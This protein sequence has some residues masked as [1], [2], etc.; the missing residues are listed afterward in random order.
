MARVDE[1]EMDL[2][3][4]AIKEAIQQGIKEWLADT[5]EAVGKWTI[6]G[7]VHG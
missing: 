4:E 3:K 7:L 2:Y 5:Y 6:R 1:H